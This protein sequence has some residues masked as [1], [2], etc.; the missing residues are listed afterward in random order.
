MLADARRHLG[1]ASQRGPGDLRTG[2]APAAGKFAREFAPKEADL[3][4]VVPV[5]GGPNGRSWSIAQAGDVEDVG[6][7]G[8]VAS[9]SEEAFVPGAEDLRHIL[10]AERAPVVGDLG[11]DGVEEGGLLEAFRAAEMAGERDDHVD[12]GVAADIRVMAVGEHEVE[13]K[14]QASNSLP[15]ADAHVRGGLSY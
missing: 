11:D 1:V 7:S 3:G 6:E 12:E 13:V 9:F 15:D 14:D 10:G 8:S 4:L 5:R 2:S